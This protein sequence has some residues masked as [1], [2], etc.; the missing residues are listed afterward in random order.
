[1][2][3]A[4]VASLS[5]N[6][7]TASVLADFSFLC[8]GFAAFGI[9]TFLLA[10]IQVDL[11]SL[12][13]YSST[14]LAFAAS[15]FDLNQLSARDS[16]NVLRGH[17]ADSVRGLVYP[18][19]LSLALSVGFRF[20]FF[21][22]LV[23]ERPRGEPPLT[24]QDR[25]AAYDPR[26]HAHSASWQ[27]WGYLGFIL[28]W[29]LLALT[30]VIPI[31]QIV[32]RIFQRHYGVA[33]T[34]ESTIEITLSSF[35]IL[36]LFFN[37]ILSPVSHSLVSP[38]WLRFLS[39][40]GPIVALLIGLGIGIGQLVIFAFS[41]TTLGRFLQALESYI[42][43][44]FLLMDIF[45]ITP[46]MG[47][48]QIRKAQ[49]SS[50][51]GRGGSRSSKSLPRHIRTGSIYHDT[52]DSAWNTRR[53]SPGPYSS[54]QASFFLWDRNDPELGG[55]PGQPHRTPTTEI[56]Y[57][58]FD[59]RV[60]PRL[61]S[62]RNTLLHMPSSYLKH[63]PI[64][65]GE[66]LPP[67]G[68]KMD[69]SFSSY[70]LEVHSSSL[71]APKPIFASDVSP[72]GPYSRVH[73][74]NGIIKAIG[75]RSPTRT[76]RKLLNSHSTASFDELLRQLGKLDQSVAMLRLFSPST[77]TFSDAKDATTPSAQEKLSL[78]VPTASTNTNSDTD[79]EGDSPLPSAFSLSFFPEPPT[80]GFAIPDT[81]VASLAGR[82]MVPPRPEGVSFDILKTSSTADEASGVETVDESPAIVTGTNNF[83]QPLLLDSAMQSLASLPSRD[84]YSSVDPISARQTAAPQPF[85]L[86][87][88]TSAPA[89]SSSFSATPFTVS[90]KP[91]I[92]RRRPI[93]TVGAGKQKEALKL[94]L[95]L[96]LEVDIAIQ[97]K[98][99]GDI[100]LSLFA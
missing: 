23:A 97:A 66:V 98:V 24:L 36:K 80:Y 26:Y 65:K 71:P 31:M 100:T 70:Y 95:C 29:G 25:E 33:Y 67:L 63:T 92:R 61:Q 11:P 2:P 77:P 19:E 41:E 43:I 55:S 8:V 96:N 85:L 9:S 3:T 40:L 30:V 49:T 89:I 27:R 20:M 15:I 91:T 50:F 10:M 78:T 56:V 72:S 54:G 44:A 47:R 32:W 74:L 6:D 18:R 38:W 99:G 5:L 16:H 62:F 14:L 39:Y 58:A 7:D 88:D 35:F 28:K 87:N 46:A 68:P 76:N 51:S 34:V 81:P 83:V 42:L 45:Y 48:F 86:G 57:A 82:D 75:D 21:W 60:H 13:L 12:Y 17:D 90:R 59:V 52:L 37:A 93:P 94:R 53:K 4:A 22:M 69:V 64:N 79:A 84:N 1:M 73:E